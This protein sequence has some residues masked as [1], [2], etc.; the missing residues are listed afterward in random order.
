MGAGA[1]LIRLGPYLVF[2]PLLAVLY[3]L[4]PNSRLT[5]GWKTPFNKFVS[6]AYSYVLFIAILFAQILLDLEKN[7]PA[8]PGTSE[9]ESASLLV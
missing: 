5:H 9:S 8:P 4:A 3:L 6:F 1:R 7:H 2:L